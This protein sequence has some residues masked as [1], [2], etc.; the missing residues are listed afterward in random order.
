MK[1]VGFMLLGATTLVLLAVT[2]LAALGFSYGWVFLLIFLGQVLLIFSVYKV[3][4][5]Y[6]TT[7]KTFDDFYEHYPIDRND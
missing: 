6:Y 5:E 2:V 7:D 4:R 1:N 3:L